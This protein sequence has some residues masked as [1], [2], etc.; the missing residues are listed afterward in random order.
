MLVYVAQCQKGVKDLMHGLPTMIASIRLS[1]LLTEEM[2]HRDSV[3][4]REG[5]NNE[6]VSDNKKGRAEWSK[7]EDV[8]MTAKESL[9][10]DWQANDSDDES[11]CH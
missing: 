1:D 8:P 9:E 5:R 3:H 6:F 11:L 10:T 4:Q 7:D 2:L